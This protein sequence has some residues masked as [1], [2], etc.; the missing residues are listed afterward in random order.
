M[1]QKTYLRWYM[2]PYLIATFAE[3]TSNLCW[4][5]CRKVGT[6]ARMFWQCLYI[7]SFWSRISKLTVTVSITCILNETTVEQYPLSV[8]LDLLPFHTREIVIPI[9]FA[10]CLLITWDWKSNLVP[11]VGEVVQLVDETYG[12]EQLM[13]YKE[14]GFFKCHKQW[15]LWEVFTPNYKNT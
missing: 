8:N 5:E 15:Y 12:Y 13:A 14:G 10:A 2:T 7:W 6:L 11:T 9:L 3:E 1:A 4:K